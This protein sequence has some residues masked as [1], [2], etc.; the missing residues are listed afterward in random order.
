MLEEI[1]TCIG[2]CRFPYTPGIYTKEQIEAWKPVV[3]A[4]HDKGGIFFLQLW[5]V[6][7]QSSVDYQP[8]R[9]PP[10]SG[11]SKRNDVDKVLLENYTQVDAS[12]PHQLTTEEI[13]QMI[14]QWRI[15]A[16]NAIEAGFDG[17]ELHGGNGYLI[18]DFLKDSVNDRTDQYGPQSYE[19]RTRFVLELYDAVAAEV[20]AYRVGL[21]T[22]V[23]SFF[24]NAGTSDPIPLGL[25]LIEQLNKRDLLYLHGVEP[26]IKGNIEVESSVLL[27]LDLFILQLLS[28]LAAL[29]RDRTHILFQNHI[30]VCTGL[31]DV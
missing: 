11:S 17:V 30:F 27:K 16:R 2:Q 21:R 5:H 10:V 1:L 13:P 6:G 3:K 20:G 19:N 4:V 26:G 25:Y 9:Q 15:A 12:K 24:N 18:E 14:D 7:R 8:N 31:N 22:S 28:I 29:L 23:F